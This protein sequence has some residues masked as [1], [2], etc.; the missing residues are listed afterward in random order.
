[1]IRVEDDSISFIDAIMFLEKIKC[2]PDIVFHCLHVARKSYKIAQQINVKGGSKIKNINS[3][4]VFIG[5][6]LHDAGRAESHGI[7]H[8]IKGANLIRKHLKNEKLALMTERHIGGGIDK[9]EA[10]IF[11]LPIKDYI[12][13]SIEEK[14]I[15]YADKLFQYQLDEENRILNWEEF[16]NIEKEVEKMEKKLGKNHIAIKRLIQIESEIKS[17]LS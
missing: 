12:P 17:L 6:L 15:C 7:D 9:N 13:I 11:N 2:P 5:G 10:K 4:V 3:N 8:G 16:N 1:M 14:I